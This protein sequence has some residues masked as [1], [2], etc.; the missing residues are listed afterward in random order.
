MQADEANP[1]KPAPA[2]IPAGVIRHES[3]PG[4][5]LC[6][7]PSTNDFLG[8]AV[9]MD[10]AA[11]TACVDR[12]RAAQ[13]AWA[14]TTFSQ[15]RRVMRML[16]KAILARQDDIC[17]LST[18][19]SGK[20]R[21]DALLGEIMTTCE[22]I[23]WINREGEAALATSY[24]KTNLMMMHK[25]ARVEYV[26]VGV[27]GVI[28]P[29]NYPFHNMLNHIIS[30][31]FA[32]NAVVSKASEYT[33]WCG[34]YY[35]R[36]VREVL[37]AAGHDPEL[38][39]LV[40]GFADAGAALVGS[41]VDKIIFTGSPGIGRHV[42]LGCAKVLKPVVLELGG[43]DPVIVCEDADFEQVIN[44]TM[45]GVYVCWLALAVFRCVWLCVY[46]CG[47]PW[48]AV[49]GCVWLCVAVCVFLL[50]CVVPHATTVAPTP[51][52][53]ATPARTASASSACTSTRASTTSS[54]SA[55]PPT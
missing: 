14:Q 20:T 12:A 44:Y 8:E 36:L 27:L 16:N 5:I 47:W 2:G 55:S 53:S 32:G 9:A 21:M 48:A 52:A 46:G 10:A 50:A 40:T 34:T 24:R 41:S 54:C 3:R 30:G 6:W 13:V 49:C 43:K 17:R 19:D 37:A 51:A 31:L 45:R 42:M 29:W 28:A 15:R 39:Q 4:K 25:S 35:L 33:S 1:V 38:V 18:R 11:V 22:K 23:A 26:P 7:D